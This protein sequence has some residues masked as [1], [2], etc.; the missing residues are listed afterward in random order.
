M[1]TACFARIKSICW[2]F[3]GYHKR[4]FLWRY[5]CF[6]IAWGKA[7]T[8]T[9]H[10]TEIERERNLN[11]REWKAI[12]SF[13]AFPQH[14]VLFC[15]SQA[16][17]KL[18]ATCSWIQFFFHFGLSPSFFFNGARIKVFFSNFIHFFAACFQR[19]LVSLFEC[20]LFNCDPGVCFF[21]CLQ[22][23]FRFNSF[24]KHTDCIC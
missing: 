3:I 18:T 12:I 15:L 11:R 9:N 4:H 6:Q 13:M 16:I 8:T 21:V 20:V 1:S 7:T 17:R 2:L 23:N 14:F 24:Q 22:F 19:H 5:R 10:E